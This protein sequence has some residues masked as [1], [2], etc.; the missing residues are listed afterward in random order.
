MA[1]K[2]DWSL[3]DENRKKIR[4]QASIIDM[5][6]EFKRLL[7]LYTSKYMLIYRQ[8]TRQN[9]SRRSL[10]PHLFDNYVIEGS[11]IVKTG[12]WSRS[13]VG[14]HTRKKVMSVNQFLS[15]KHKKEKVLDAIESLKDYEPLFELLEGKGNAS[16]ITRINN[17]T[18]RREALDFYGIK[19]FFKEMNAEIIDR[20][21]KKQELLTIRW[22]KREDPMTMVKVID[23]TTKEVYLLQVP[24]ETKTVKEAVAWTFERDP[25]DYNPIKET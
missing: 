15:L 5:N 17:A 16:T 13:R 3:I 2:I 20:D 14:T 10:T 19:R 1:K 12:N 23:S 24:P 9:R 4:K 18:L 25:D 22:H 11:N 7:N 21:H 6:Q 8:L